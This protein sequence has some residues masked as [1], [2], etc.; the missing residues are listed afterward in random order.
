MSGIPGGPPGADPKQRTRASLVRLALFGSVALLL[1]STLPRELLVA[2]LSSLLWVGGI[3][4]ALVAAFMGEPVRAPWM[5]RWDEAAVLVLASL[6]L[7]FFVD[8]QAMME[9]VEQMRG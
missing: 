4:S 1:A 2:S 8:T 5:T 9:Q 3:V 7:G 6:A